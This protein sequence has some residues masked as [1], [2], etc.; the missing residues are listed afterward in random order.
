MGRY[1][2]DQAS[3]RGIAPSQSWSADQ[4]SSAGEQARSGGTLTE[5]DGHS[6]ETWTGSY[7]GGVLTHQIAADHGIMTENQS[8]WRP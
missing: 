6:S 7:E 2:T 3:G 8:R 4:L 1:L 5:A